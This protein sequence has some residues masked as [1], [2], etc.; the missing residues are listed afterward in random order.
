MQRQNE[1]RR[2]PPGLL[3]IAAIMLIA[4]AGLCEVIYMVTPQATGDVAW[5]EGGATLD[6]SNAASGYVM[7]RKASDRKLKVRVMYQDVTY[8]YDLPG[9][10]EYEVYP[11]QQGSGAYQVV[12]Y[13][14]VRGNSYAQLLSKS[15]DVS[16]SN[17]LAAFL[18]P[19][20]YVDYTADTTAVTQASEMLEGISSDREKA[21]AVSNWIIDNFRYDFILSLTVQTGYVPDLEATMES[22]SG[23]C[24]DFASLMSAMLRT[25]GIPTQLVM[26][27]ADGMYH[28][29]CNV[30]LDGQW[31]RYDPTAVLMG[32]TIRNYTEEA[33]Y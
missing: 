9:D 12:V 28:A 25:Q 6:A 20:R 27:D 30:W 18:C 10:G 4:V 23:I 22:R 13:E 21:D 32:A 16:M 26:G 15:F 17:E 1:H 8:T 14:N 5:E 29:W 3:A 33:C 19:N 24:F 31:V 7:V 2:I 11:L